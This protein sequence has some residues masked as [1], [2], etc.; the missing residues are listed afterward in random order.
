M[1]TKFSRFIAWK[2]AISGHDSETENIISRF[3]VML[4]IQGVLM[5]GVCD[6]QFGEIVYNPG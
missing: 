2:S 5:V 4:R 6:V 1:Q 3:V